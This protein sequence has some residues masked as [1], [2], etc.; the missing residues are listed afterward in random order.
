MAD[1]ALRLGPEEAVWN[2]IYIDTCGHVAWQINNKKQTQKTTTQKAKRRS[3]SQ[4]C[5]SPSSKEAKQ[6]AKGAGPNKNNH[7]QRFAMD[8]VV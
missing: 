2:K 6:T 8:T 1:H 4:I 3:P 5:V 7:E